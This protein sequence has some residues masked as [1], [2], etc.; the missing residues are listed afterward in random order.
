MNKNKGF[1]L[2]ELMITVAILA[3]LASI[4]YPSYVEQVRKSKRTDA[5]TALYKIAQQ[6]E[7]YFIQNMSYAADLATLHNNPGVNTIDSPEQQY[8]ITISAV[9]PAGCD[10]VIGA[11]LTACVAY[12][13]TATAKVGTGQRGD[14][15]CRTLSLDNLSRETSTNDS[16]VATNVCW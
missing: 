4:A 13:A 6:Q 9:A 16:G 7:E 12:T 8:D 2:I 1:T 10:S 3:I 11:G 5:K 14:K 15:A